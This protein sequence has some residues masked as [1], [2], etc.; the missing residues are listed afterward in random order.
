V[1]DIGNIIILRIAF[2]NTSC[3]LPDDLQ[4]SPRMGAK[5]I[6]TYKLAKVGERTLFPLELQV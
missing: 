3:P 2:M 5:T 6:E 1:A 4:Y